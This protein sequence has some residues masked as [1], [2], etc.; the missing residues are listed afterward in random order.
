MGWYSSQTTIGR[1][2][3][4]RMRVLIAV[5]RQEMRA[6][7]GLLLSQEPDTRVVGES[8][9]SQELLASL[10]AVYPDVV[11]LDCELPGL[12]TTDLLAQLYAHNPTLRVLILCSKTEREQAAPAAGA[13]TFV[14]KTVHPK[15]LVTAL[16]VLQLES[17]YE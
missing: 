13:R 1:A 16:R 5:P 11:L 15:H 9:N 4:I 12:P 8:G 10:E 6:A 17:E 14:D 3:G 7:L 2:T